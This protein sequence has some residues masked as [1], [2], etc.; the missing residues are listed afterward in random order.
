MT[1]GRNTLSFEIA[2]KNPPAIAG[3]TDLMTPGRKALLFENFGNSL[4]SFLF[5][6][7]LVH[8][9]KIRNPKF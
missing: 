5:Q 8:R 9:L 4:V 3:G 7:V 6:V 2:N 1:P